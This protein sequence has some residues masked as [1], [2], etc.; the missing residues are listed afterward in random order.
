MGGLAGGIAASV[1]AT[2]V[3]RAG[4]EPKPIVVPV[5]V[6]IAER[7]VEVDGKKTTA[8]VVPRSFVDD[9]LARANEIFEPYAISF[10]LRGELRAA[11]KKLAVLETRADRDAVCE[12]MVKGV[13][14]LFFVTSLRDVD[15][16]SRH[17]MGVTWRKLTNLKKK[18]VIVAASALPT[19]LAHELGH[20]LGND[21]TSV[22]NNL[23][24]YDRDG[25][26]VF[27]DATQGAKA[28]KT[29]MGL[30]ATKELLP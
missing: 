21:H 4:Q 26:K 24:S 15:D 18:V 16:P 20:Y 27:L 13:A 14:N 28:R 8:P 12:A 10:A 19:T 9:Q 23:M 3:A 7:E 29:A 2:R 25:A 11:D 30:F 5:G 6:A 1:A 22:K 17:R